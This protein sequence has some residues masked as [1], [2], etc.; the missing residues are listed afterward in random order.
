MTAIFV[1]F[2]SRPEFQPPW[3]HRSYLTKVSPSRLS[4]HQVE[5]MATQVASGK[6]LPADVIEQLVEKTDGVPLYV[7]EMTK[8][9]LESGVL[10]ESNGQYERVGSMTS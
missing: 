6:A 10:K 8:A 5:Q 3:P 7:E 2:T 1:L 9:V 4:R